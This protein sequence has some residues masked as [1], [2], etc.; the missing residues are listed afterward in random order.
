MFCVLFQCKQCIY[1]DKNDA[2]L[3]EKN[4]GSVIHKYTRQRT[5]NVSFNT[6][7]IIIFFIRYNKINLYTPN[8][9]RLANNAFNMF[10][11][12]ITNPTGNTEAEEAPNITFFQKMCSEKR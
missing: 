8:V 1:N 12:N 2:V 7:M 10:K 6:C 5:R 4:M 3:L 9:Y 11:R